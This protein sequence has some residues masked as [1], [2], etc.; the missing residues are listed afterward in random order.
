[1]RTAI[2]A[3]L[4]TLAISPLLATAASP[5]GWFLA[6]SEPGSYSMDRDSVVTHG[7]SRSGRLASIQPSKGFGTMMQSIDAVDYAG[8][9]MRL[10][11][12]VKSSDVKRWAGV[13]MR[14]D[15][16]STQRG[17]LAFDN[18][19]DRPIKG[20][21]D[22]TRCDIVLDVAKGAKGIYYGILLD[23]EGT[24]WM[25]DIQFEAVPTTVP[26]TDKIGAPMKRKPANLDFGH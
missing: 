14:V 10:S 1:M 3:A 19:Q 22:W 17:S 4:L 2:M 8:K 26:T 11:A 7:T 21:Q 25:S 5:Q 20:T 13:W 18:M 6:G 12:W 9:R 23:G 15:G 16:A 24:V